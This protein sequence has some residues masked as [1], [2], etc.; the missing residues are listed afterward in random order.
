MECDALDQLFRSVAASQ[1]R[2]LVVRGEAGV[3]KTALLDYLA[4][5]ASVCR[6]VRAAGIESEMELPYAGVHQLCASMLHRL[7]ALPVPQLDALNTAFGLNPGATPDRF[8]VGLAVLSLLS[9]AAEE[10]PLLCLVDDAQWLDRASA[11]VL[12]FVARRLLAEPVGLVFAIRE[13][14][15]RTEF[16]GLPAL[17]VGGLGDDDARA[18]L[19]WAVPGRLD[20]RVRD[21]IV[22]ETHGNP[23]A[24][25]ELPRGLSAAQLAGGFGLTDP[26]PLASRIEQSFVRR[27]QSLP[28]ETQRLLLT[29][30][31]E[32]VGDVAL[33][34]RAAHDLGI[35]LAAAAPAIEEGLVELGARVRFSH[36]LVRSAVYR[37]AALPDRQA[38]HRALAAATDPDSD[39]DRRAWHRAHAAVGPDEAVA[40]ELEQSA[41]RAK[42]RGGVAAAAAF[43]ARATEL[44]PEPARRGTRALAAAQAKF[45]AA[46]PDAAHQLL[47]VA[48]LG[49]LDDLQLARVT[50]LRAQ[51]VFARNRGRDAPPLLLDGARRFEGL[52]DALARETYLEAFAAAIYAGR[53][54]LPATA[55]QIAEAARAAPPSGLTRPID[56]LVDGLATRFIDGCDAGVPLLGRALR[57][58]VSE[59]GD[60]E[61]DLRWLWLASPIAFEAW[62]DEAWD[63]MTARAV[64]VARDSG[65]LAVLRV[66]L[67]YRAGV[68]IHGGDFAAGSTLLEEADAIS[69]ATGLT[70]VGKYAWQVL[71]A[72]RGDEARVN[73]LTETDLA[74]ATARGEGRVIAVIGF[75]TA[76]LYNGLG[77]YPEALSSARGACEH[78]DLGLFGW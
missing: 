15:D 60:N 6:N 22:A 4:S 10:G 12:A 46:A 20:E 21:R 59:P 39:P 7:P 19:E 9:E 66:A 56:L 69:V 70:P 62:D 30:A 23:L 3:G 24:L 61:T 57:A 2:V 33:L 72:W 11:Q 5:K 44:T 13:P 63:R 78:E 40:N 65:A 29:A 54:G 27:L 26:R 32:P 8:L 17:M 34:T 35:D 64:K 47:T 49:P 1:S 75:A 45:E 67:A 18:L 48:E 37:A 50:R 28:G 73:R 58:I 55:Q 68:H 36:P 38:I 16:D 53:L 74:D 71:A 51:I 31:A 25:L 76:L 43:L 77:R 14:S 52:D 41:G 42:R